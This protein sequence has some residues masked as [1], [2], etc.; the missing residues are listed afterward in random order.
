MTINKI[1][2]YGRLIT[3]CCFTVLLICFI[4]HPIQAE[5][6]TQEFR[7]PSGYLSIVYK[8]EAYRG[9]GSFY[10]NENNKLT[11]IL[12]TEIRYG[13][14]INWFGDDIAEIFIPHGSPFNSSYIYNAKTKKIS[15]RLDN[16]IT[17]FPQDDIV[18]FT[19]WER[20][21]FAKISTQ[22]ILQ[23][24]EIEG[25]ACSYMAT[26]DYFDV[27][28]D[29]GDIAIGIAYELYTHKELDSFKYYKFKREF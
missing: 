2:F 16:L 20:F 4:P 7:N 19:D 23:E 17:I 26:R 24:I 9:K 10:L 1:S 21:L 5:I 28:L 11:P 15:G 29:Q 13:P 27:S 25:A 18:V 12:D 22:M 14:M 8:G 3:V 6:I